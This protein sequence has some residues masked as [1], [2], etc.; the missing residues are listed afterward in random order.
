MVR[1][2]GYAKSVQ[3]FENIV[4]HGQRNRHAHPHQG[5]RPGGPGPGPAPGRRRPRRQRG[6]R[7]RHRRHAPGAERPRCHRPGQ[8]EDPGDRAGPARRREDR[9][10]LRPLGPDPALHRQPEVDAH[11]GDPHGRAGHPPL[12]LAHPER[13]HPDDH[14]PGRGPALL[15]PLPDD[16][17]HG[18]HH[19]ARRALPSPSAPWWMPPSWWWSRPTRSLEQWE[20]TGRQGGLPDGRRQ[21][22]QAGGR[23]ELLRP[24][25]D[26]RLLPAGAH[27]GGPGRPALQAAG[28]HEE[29]LHDHRRRAGHH[30]GPGPAAA[31]HP[32]EEL[33]TSGPRWLCRVANAVV[34]GHAS[35]PRKS[36]R[37]AAF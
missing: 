1:G 15:H 3:D 4:A 29:P 11:R 14:H 37:S 23:P 36:T 19:V 8:G 2:R 27:P 21:R 26:R 22:R 25:G 18:Q 35:I 13:H 9:P 32:H 24:A 6:G 12:P 31:L 33:S 7:L 20:R 34:R 10:H 28:L 16:G 5:H 30:P 17:D